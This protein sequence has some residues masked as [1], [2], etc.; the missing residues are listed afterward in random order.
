MST[1][2]KVFVS[3]AS[4]DR[5]RFVMAFARRLRENGVDAWLDQWEMKPGDS[6]VDRIFE[7]GLGQAQ[8]VVIVLSQASVDKPWVREELNISVVK[9]L[10]K[11]L[12][13]IPVVI[14]A[15]EIPQCLL[16]TLWQR[17]DDLQSYDE[18]FQRILA[19]IFD[20]SVKPPLGEAPERFSSA[21]KLPGNTGTDDRVLGAI[22]RSE[23]EG[24][25]SY[26]DFE[27][28]RAVPELAD[29]P[30]DELLASL[31]ILQAKGLI[32]LEHT[33]A[34]LPLARLTTA[35][36]RHF[37]EAY[38]EAYPQLLAQVGA[39][40]VNEEQFE[41]H[42]IAERIGQ[43]VSFVNLLLDV[44]QAAGHVKLAKFGSGVWEVAYV[45][46]TLKRSLQTGA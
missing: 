27:E 4:E 21:P 28:L 16:S 7:Q 14:D 43:P 35:G 20:T 46:P 15:C 9:R 1:Q 23:V 29:A 41:N 22:Y 45:S 2:P 24:Q 8:A 13:I 39:L 37:A 32:H 19:A 10:Q 40:L 17:I 11:G 31:E 38:V 33:G 18:A 3:H 6:L 26:L 30:Q 12:K 5:Q 36:F 44:L 42:R 25:R 34:P